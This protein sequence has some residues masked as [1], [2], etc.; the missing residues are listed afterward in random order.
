MIVAKE[1]QR[2]DVK[3]WCPMCEK[4]RIIRMYHETGVLFYLERG[5]EGLCEDCGV[6]MEIID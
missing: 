4:T 3:H 2:E 5:E 6:E 1:G